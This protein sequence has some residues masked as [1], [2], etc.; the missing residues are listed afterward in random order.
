MHETPDTFYQPLPTPAQVAT[1]GAPSAPCADDLTRIFNTAL[2][3]TRAEVGRDYSSELLRLTDSPAFRAILGSVRQL[4]L[5]QGVSEKDA[6]EAVVQTF[7]K[8]DRVW[9]DYLCQEGLDRLKSQLP[10]G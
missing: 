8:V 6:A 1:S 10:Q 9:G 4:A 5:T 3:A 7:R 2:V